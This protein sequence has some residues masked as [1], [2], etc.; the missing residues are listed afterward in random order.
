VPV[1][2]TDRSDPA[3][4]PTAEPAGALQV[5]SS[6]SSAESA[7]TGA[8]ILRG[9]LWNMISRL[10][11]Q[12]Y[13]IATS[14][15]AGRLLGASGLG[16]LSFIAFVEATLVV[17]CSLGLPV[18]LMRY[19]GE[20]LGRGNSG[21][22][23]PLVRWGWHI[24]LVSGGVGFAIMAGAAGLGATPHAAWLFAGLACWL[25]VLHN[26]PSAILIGAQRWREATIVGLTTGTG[27]MA[28]KVIVLAEGQGIVAL[29]VVDAVAAFLNIVG[30]SY[31]ARRAQARFTGP[32]D[33]SGDIVRR[34]LRFAAIQSIGVVV[35]FVVWRRTELFF[36]DR[37]SS[38]AQIA[39][40]SVP[41][42]AVSAL[43]LVPLAISSTITPA[44]AT[45]SGAGATDRIRTGYWRTMRLIVTVTLPVT[46]IAMSVGPSLLVLAYGSQFKGIT[47]I[48]LILLGAFPVVPLLYTATALLIGVERQA[49]TI[50]AGSLAAVLNIALDFVLIRQFDAVGGAIANSTA[51]VIGSIPVVIY[52]GRIV[53]GTD[54][55][56]RP[57]IRTAAASLLSAGAAVA[58][59]LATRPLLGVP[60]AIVAFC[61]VFFVAAGRIHILDREDATWLEATVGNRFGGVIAALCRY[62]AARG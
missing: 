46:A 3:A 40:Y 21:E 52:A 48:L 37:Y 55:R 9:G 1:S 12:A 26:I 45:L 4:I 56:P 33:P 49:L 42:S 61:L 17:G 38:N 2:R 54:W 36:L 60:A 28:A 11:P 31:L 23:R 39:L 41:F 29:F 5:D 18:S 50:I 58:V 62:A 16:R 19:I 8:T 35:T 32:R 59:I 7:T 14:I 34:M 24:E 13:T 27:A 6:R 30:T 15:V 44:I 47:P 10:L 43:L 57:V 20:T 25:I 53:G 22:V 51:Q